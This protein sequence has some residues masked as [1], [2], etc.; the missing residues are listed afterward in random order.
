MAKYYNDDVVVEAERLL[1]DNWD[2]V[3]V[4][5]GVGNLVDG[6]P[7][8]CFVGHN[9]SEDGGNM[10]LIIPRDGACQVACEG[11][12]VFRSQYGTLFSMPSE[13][14]EQTYDRRV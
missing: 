7:E 13:R 6:K 9:G 4:L 11:D 3:C 1:W 5:A 2:N 10:G 12:Y 8:G 14:F